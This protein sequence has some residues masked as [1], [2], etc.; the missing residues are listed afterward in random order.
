MLQSDRGTLQ[1]CHA[2]YPCTLCA[3]VARLPSTLSLV[4]RLHRLPTDPDLLNYKKPKSQFSNLIL[5]SGSHP[6]KLIN[7][8][9]IKILNR[10]RTGS[11][12]E[13]MLR[14]P[15]VEVTSPDY[16]SYDGIFLNDIDATLLCARP[17]L[18]PYTPESID[19][20]SP[21][22]EGASTVSDDLSAEMIDI[23]GEARIE[24]IR[25]KTN[26]DRSVS[27][28]QLKS[29]LDM[30]LNS[31]KELKPFLKAKESV[32]ELHRLQSRESCRSNNS[33][34]GGLCCLAL[35]C[36]GFCR[37]RAR[38]VDCSAPMTCRSGCCTS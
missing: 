7:D 11:L 5:T 33:K 18:Y 31:E 13:T 14:I 22:V 36:Y 28:S 10:T 35:K 37:R 16:S 12:N 4:P 26:V 32:P 29:R 25:F 30:L 9:S 6:D 24:T 17:C 27:P 1:C 38:R 15:H 3:S 19:S 8:E 23:L 34:V 20:H 2:C 21:N